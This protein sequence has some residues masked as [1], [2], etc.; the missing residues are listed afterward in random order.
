MDER[1]LEGAILERLRAFKDLTT[2]EICERQRLE[3]KFGGKSGNSRRIRKLLDAISQELKG[4]PIGALEVFRKSGLRICVC[5]ILK[6][7]EAA[8][9]VSF[10][11]F[12]YAEVADED[13]WDDSS[14]YQDLV[15]RFLFVFLRDDEDGTSPR[16]DRVVFWSMPEAD[17]N[18][19]QSVWENTVS[20]IRQNRLE[21]L[22][23]EADTYAVHVRPHDRNRYPG[24]KRSFWFNRCYVTKIWAG[25]A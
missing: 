4:M 13:E 19:T 24:F 25:C 15:K 22:P 3:G 23:A 14:L 20:L 6:N 8:E 7:D 17:L 2:V 18:I 21:E 9:A 16:F 11:A 10:P 5:R 12:E 1:D